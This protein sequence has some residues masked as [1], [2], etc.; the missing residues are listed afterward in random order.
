MEAFKE[1]HVK[2]AITGLSAILGGKLSI[3][4]LGE[5]T[6]IYQNKNAADLQRQTIKVHQWVRIKSG[7]YAGDLGLV[8]STAAG[9]KIWLRV[10]P[11]VEMN[12][13]K[14]GDAKASRFAIRPPQKAFNKDEA[15]KHN[16]GVPLETKKENDMSGKSFILF[17]K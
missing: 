6:G 7:L 14:Q 16:G 1:I 9:N 11:R 15:R 8:E 17:K 12:P 5:M 10:I 2:E 4:E 3:I 13:K